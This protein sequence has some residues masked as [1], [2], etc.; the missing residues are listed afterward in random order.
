MECEL[1]EEDDWVVVRKQKITILVSPPSPRP[2]QSTSSEKSKSRIVK[3]SLSARNERRTGFIEDKHQEPTAIPAAGNVSLADGIG[4][5][6]R[7]PELV[8]NPVTSPKKLELPSWT[9]ANGCRKGISMH[10]KSIHVPRLLPLPIGSLNF[11]NQRVRALN[12]ERELKGLGG[13]RR[14][15]GS[16]GLGRFINVFKREKVGR[17]QLANL[18]M[19]MLKDMGTDAVGP[20]RK[21]IHAIDHLCQPYYFKAL[22]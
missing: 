9:K 21:L 7:A 15:L 3:R 5:S 20:R 16:Q 22:H 11:V 12:L 14:W 19:R 18:T 13:L 1:E 2:Q 17:H 8:F 6:S 10:R 4:I